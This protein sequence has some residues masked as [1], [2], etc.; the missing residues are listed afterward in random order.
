MGAGGPPVTRVL[1]VED[2]R[3][4]TDPLAVTLTGQGFSTAV[5][6]TGPHAL[7]EFARRGADIVLLDLVL[8]GMLGTEVC[9]ALRTRSSVPVIIVSARDSELDRVLAFELGADDYVSRPYSSR[10][11]IARVRAV[12]RRRRP[13]DDAGTDPDLLRAGPISMDVRRHRVTVSGSEVALRLRE[14]E[15]LEYLLRNTGRVVTRGQIL[16]R[17]WGPD[18]SCAKT[19]DVH[20]N[21]LRARIEPDPAVPRHVL[22]IRGMGYRLAP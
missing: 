2:D 11:L 13:P 16:D 14:F 3:T 5:V 1:V 22:T 10:E 4:V 6:R 15:L 19:V 21:R 7:D 17:V 8:P 12:L 18:R 9:R 20:V